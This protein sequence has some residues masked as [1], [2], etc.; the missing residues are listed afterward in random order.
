MF[1][2]S[3]TNFQITF[4][5]HLLRCPS[6]FQQ[7]ALQVH[8]E[9]KNIWSAS[10]IT[11]VYLRSSQ[12]LLFAATTYCPAH[13]AQHS[14]RTCVHMFQKQS[15]VWVSPTKSSVLKPSRVN[16]AEL[17]PVIANFSS[18][19]PFIIKDFVT[20]SF[21]WWIDAEQISRK[22]SKSRSKKEK[23]GKLM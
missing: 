16:H 8:A 22:A 6:D 14:L 2:F 4:A 20:A 21:F 13:H 9:N 17:P 7:H 5:K 18:F 15:T 19:R 23:M 3:D 11:C 12:S 1:S 10:H